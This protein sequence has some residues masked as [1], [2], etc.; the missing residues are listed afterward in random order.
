M[1][2]FPSIMTPAARS[3]A[4]IPESLGSVAPFNAKDPATPI[5]YWRKMCTDEW[6][7]RLCS[8]CLW[9]LYS[10]S[11]AWEA[12]AGDWKGCELTCQLFEEAD[13]IPSQC[14]IDS[15]GIEKCCIY[16]CIGIQLSD[17]VQG[18]IDLI[19]SCNICLAVIQPLL[20]LRTTEGQV[21]EKEELHH[22]MTRST[23]VKQPR[24]SPSARSSTVASMRLGRCL[25]S[26]FE[27]SIE[28]SVKWI[29]SFTSNATIRAATHERRQTPNY[30][31]TAHD[32]KRDHYFSWWE[33]GYGQKLIGT[34]LSVVKLRKRAREQRCKHGF[35]QRHL[36]ILRIYKEQQNN[37]GWK[38]PVWGILIS[39]TCWKC[40]SFLPQ[41]YAPVAFIS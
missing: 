34:N 1:V 2:D 13:E 40:E 17:R 11:P 32:L 19:D 25:S 27:K 6:S 38:Q 12:H 20:L 3:L 37:S 24:S 14:A 8:S 33:A 4:A 29:A 36:H 30:Q 39:W 28:M 31:K 9:F 16:Q 18:R 5:K 10:F 41:D 7:Y 35:V 22:T 21:I 15:F 23:L 26:E